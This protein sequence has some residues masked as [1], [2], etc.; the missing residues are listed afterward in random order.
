MSGN[1]RQAAG[2]SMMQV[3]QQLARTT[4]ETSR[5]LEYFSEKELAMQLGAGRDLW[6]LVLVKELI[7]NGLDACES[8][9]ILPEI[10]LYLSDN[11]FAVRDNGQGLP[12]STLERSLDYS[13][14]VSDKNFY[15]SPSRGQLGNALKALWAAPF[16]ADGENGK[17]EVSMA[18]RTH[19]IAVSLD[20]IEQRPVLSHT[21][22][23]G[24]LN[25]GTLVKIPC[26][27]LVE[28]ASSDDPSEESDF[29]NGA[30]DALFAYA[31][32][33]P[34][35]TFVL[36][37][38]RGHGPIILPRAS[39]TWRHWLPSEPTSP[40]WYSVE[41]FINL[42]SAY[43]SRDRAT[44]KDKTVREFVS[45]FRGLAGTAKQKEIAQESGLAG[46]CVKDLVV[47]GA[48]DG[49]LSNRLLSAMKSRSTPVKPEMLGAVGEENFLYW[50][51]KIYGV[52]S[53]T[54]RYRRAK[55]TTSQGLPFVVEAAFAKKNAEDETSRTV[56]CGV[57]WSPVIGE[58]IGAVEALLGWQRVDDFDDVVVAV[59][60]A[61]PS[62]EFTDRGKRSLSLPDEIDN[63]L[64]SCVENVTAGW[65][66][67]K[68]K[69]D[70]DDHVRERDLEALRKREKPMSIKEAAFQVMEQAYMDASGDG[71]YPAHGRQIM[72]SARP[73]VLELTGGKFWA[74]SAYFTQE[75]LQAF[76]E[77]NPELTAG[78]DVVF[79]ARGHLTEPHS[80]VQI[81][82]G[83]LNVRQYIAGWTSHRVGDG[84]GALPSFKR[85]VDTSGP[86]NRFGFALFIE[87]EGFDPLLERAQIAAR[88]DLAIMST[89]GMSVTAARKLV[90]ELSF[91]GV[92][93][94]VVHDFDKSGFSILQTLQSDSRRYTFKNKPRVIDLGLRLA[95]VQDMNLESEPVS[96]PS[97]IDPRENLRENG[98]TE[99]ECDF[100][101]QRFGPGWSGQRVELNA[102]TS[103]Q[104]VE[105]LEKKLAATGVAKLVPDDEALAAAYKRAV[106]LKEL[107]RLTSEAKRKTDSM[108]I[109]VPKGVA[110]KVK[111]AI[112]G[113]GTPWDLAV[114]H[115][116]AE[117]K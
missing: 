105:W 67:L 74:N 71:Q 84:R 22:R 38:D 58:P 102:M 3:P 12:A 64:T 73:S 101:V 95:D 4:F 46:A 70:R 32:F 108:E 54:I 25:K 24:G 53:S 48:V 11:G 59:H 26:P 106:R 75:L 6:A 80:G 91:H 82:L 62:L 65:K 7:D 17:V 2:D 99:D 100:L 77:E 51:V 96:Y 109:S 63:A 13:V 93:V 52:D 78:W 43:L 1:R 9:G 40:W 76:M 117:K 107:E 85:M 103:P 83:T 44:G 28:Q 45:E 104:F 112:K 55:G 36:R 41:K 35:A 18:G 8:V 72:Y 31:L 21:I 111:K 16:V 89:K 34:H 33:N 90:D 110:A 10:R 5:L 68:K 94:L 50:L 27:K 87:K 47:N 79:D 29:Y 97:K 56:A 30:I 15:I 57:N 86:R 23:V 20:R 98:A 39:D 66:K 69:S 60:I 14:R 113:K 19:T 37:T 114:W 61:C 92:T 49:N 42:I 81:G 88:F 116:A 115:L